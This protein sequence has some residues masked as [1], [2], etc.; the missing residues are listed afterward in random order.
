MK[1]DIKYYRNFPE[2]LEAAGYCPCG[3][4]AHTTGR[5]RMPQGRGR[6]ILTSIRCASC[7]RLLT[8]GL[9]GKI[10]AAVIPDQLVLQEPSYG[11]HIDGWSNE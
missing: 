8:W 9:R 1:T 11:S 2:A 7:G 6:P 3:E 5:E 10:R 4:L